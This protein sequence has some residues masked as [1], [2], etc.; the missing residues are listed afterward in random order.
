MMTTS[1]NTAPAALASASRGASSPTKSP[2]PPKAAGR[3]AHPTQALPIVKTTFHGQSP[4][5]ALQLVALEV[6]A[7][8][9]RTRTKPA[10]KAKQPTSIP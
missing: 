8:V 9:P 6:A 2:A 10:A 4:W 1:S 3:G 5:A 7:A